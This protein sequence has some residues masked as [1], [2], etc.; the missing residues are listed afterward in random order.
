MR[1]YLVIMP[2]LC[3]LLNGEEVSVPLSNGSNYAIDNPYGF[4]RRLAIIDHLKEH[5]GI[6]LKPGASETEVIAQLNDAIA[7]SVTNSPS[8]SVTTTPTTTNNRPLSKNREPAVTQE[9]RV[10]NGVDRVDRENIRIQL[11]GD[12]NYTLSQKDSLDKARSIL[13][14][15]QEERRKTEEER[16]ADPEIKQRRI[17]RE[18]ALKAIQE[19]EEGVR[20]T[21]SKRLKIIEGKIE[22]SKKIIEELDA[23]EKNALTRREFEGKVMG[24][25]KETVI[26]E[27]GKP[28]DSSANVDLTGTTEYLYY[29]LRTKFSAESRT[30]DKS[31]QVVIENGICRSINY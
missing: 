8:K 4:E 13:V 5:F 26:Q 14:K 10:N 11:K 12:F 3:C 27:V 7:K 28:D 24:K 9:P 30:L 16:E 21:R 31:A 1:I 2:L 23:L 6:Q 15:L 29:R 25:R 20:L 19:E 22:E 17:E 18:K